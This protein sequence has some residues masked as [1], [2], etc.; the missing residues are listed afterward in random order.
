MADAR[1]TVGHW[2]G[3]QDGWLQWL[4]PEA[5]AFCCVRLNPDT[6]GPAEIR[7]FYGGLAGQR[8][9][10]APGPWFND[11]AHVMRIGLAYETGGQ[12]EKGLAVISDALRP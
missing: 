11:S 7:R 4:R 10:V 9:V 3:E 12:L 6:F 2:V 5:G 1:A 8:T